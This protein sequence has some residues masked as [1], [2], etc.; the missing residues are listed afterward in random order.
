MDVES[1]GKALQAF[2]WSPLWVA[3]GWSSLRSHLPLTGNVDGIAFQAQPLATRKHQVAFEVQ[4]LSDQQP[5]SQQQAQIYAAI[6]TQAP[7]PYLILVSADRQRSLWYWQT[8]ELDQPEVEPFLCRRV[9]IQGQALSGGYRWADALWWQAWGGVTETAV[10]DADLVAAIK[11]QHQHLTAAIQGIPAQRDRSRYAAVVLNR[12]WLLC[13]LQT[14]GGLDGDEWY[15]QNKLGQGLQQGTDQFFTTFLQ[16]LWLQ[17]L[18]LPDSERT[19]SIIAKVGQVPYLG[20]SLFQPHPL[21][22]TY[23]GIAIADAPFEH[24]LDWS[25]Q[26]H[27]CLSAH[28]PRST[29]D[30]TLHNWGQ[31]L[32]AWVHEGSQRSL[33][34]PPALPQSLSKGLLDR[35]LLERI[36][37]LTPKR[38][39]SWEDCLWQADATLLQTVLAQVLTDFTLLDPAC[40]AGTYLVTLVDYWRTLHSQLVAL[41]SP[42]QSVQPPSSPGLMHAL[43]TQCLYGLDRDPMAVEVAQLQV[44][45]RVLAAM[46][47]ATISQPLPHL[48]F[49]LMAGNA[50][51]GLIRVDEAGFDQIPG[52]RKFLPLEQAN[53]VLQGNLLQ[54]LI[55]EN[56]RTILAEKQIHL[57]Y[58]RTQ[59]DLLAELAEIPPYAQADFL[60]EHLRDLNDNAQAKLNHL[61]LN[62]F[63]QKLGIRWPQKPRRRLLT[64]TDIESFHPFHWGF[65]FNT[66][67][68]TRQG[69]DGILTHPPWGSVIPQV[70]P[71]W[72]QEQPTPDLVSF[73]QT[74]QP[75][76]Q[77]P[78]WAQA[79]QT[80]RSQL[81]CF[82]TYIRRSEAYVESSVFSRLTWEQLLMQRCA[83]LLRPGGICIGVLP[84]KLCQTWASQPTAGATA[85]H[86]Q[87]GAVWANQ[88]RLFPSHP[89]RANLGCL[90]GIKV[91]APPMESNCL[92]IQAD[93]LTEAQLSVLLQRL[94]DLSP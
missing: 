90:V 65:Q 24:L 35:L 21:E 86:W 88:Q 85:L 70:E 46:P 38:F 72:R 34:I 53:P 33:A 83:Q 10:P 47:I 93:P 9:F 2:D 18:A 44:T 36:H 71:F 80:Y 20:G 28:A 94:I 52:R 26:Y 57:E 40:G 69:F 48:D 1:L 14:G 73:K 75:W 11:H 29:T 13:F 25:S 12:L 55:A 5:S 87:V 41:A 45:L 79:W 27:W 49:N 42:D 76:L 4:I 78:L 32:T 81:A 67:L 84:G 39:E 17:G 23:P 62:E 7:D 58:Y 43:L 82:K 59:T 68:T 3:L 16:P 51:V 91:T 60:R 64:I 15:L 19:A 6:A 22:Q 63:S 37:T 66:I 31:A 30:I 92:L 8:T 50:W 74:S 56:Y 77:D 61:L 54:P 89:P